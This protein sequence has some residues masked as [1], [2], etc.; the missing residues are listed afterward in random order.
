M[1]YEK[2]LVKEYGFDTDI[3]IR[4]MHIPAGDWICFRIGEDYEGYEKE[5]L[6]NFLKL[7]GKDGEL[8]DSLNK[9]AIPAWNIDEILCSYSSDKKGVVNHLYNK[10]TEDELYSFAGN[11]FLSDYAKR[12]LRNILLSNFDEPLCAP[13]EKAR[14]G[15]VYVLYAKEVNRYKIGMT[16]RT[17][18]IR[19]KEFSPKLPFDVEVFKT[20]ETE[21]ALNLESELHKM[22]SDLRLNNSEWFS[23]SNK[24]VE[25]IRGL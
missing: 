6:G 2:D 4:F 20:I 17:P 16:N 3:D 8:C 15:W 10:Y 7:S 5:K 21:D 23:L 14:V 22:F 25:Y 13:K 1:S 12:I 9:E 18:E 11:D 19:I 24:D